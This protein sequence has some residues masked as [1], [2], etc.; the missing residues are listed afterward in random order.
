LTY[1]AFTESFR[2]HPQ[3]LMS[4]GGAAEAQRE[5]KRA[6]NAYGAFDNG[7]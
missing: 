3:M 4:I 6:F 7:T 5:A 1:A 2:V